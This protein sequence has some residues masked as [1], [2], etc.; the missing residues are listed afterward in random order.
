MENYVKTGE[1]CKIL[2]VHNQTLY[3]WADRG[4]IEMKRTPGND[5]LFNVSKFLQDNKFIEKKEEKIVRRKICYCRVS[6]QGQK[7]DLIRQVNYM[8]EKY[9]NHELIKDVGSG[10]NYKRNGL[11]KIIDYAIKGEIEELVIAY[12]DR[13]CRIGY[14]L[15]ELLIEKY[16]NGKIIILNNIIE[17]PNEEIVKDLVQI[18]NVFS[19]RINGLRKYG[20]TIQDNKLT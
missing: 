2:K 14:E 17:S 13:L 6:T 18:I 16:S 10:I 4:K 15:I 19:A 11:I 5:R 1:A 20:K 3:R 8:K 9:P 12:K 7:D